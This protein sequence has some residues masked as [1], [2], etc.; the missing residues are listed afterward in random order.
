M[1][2]GRP[3]RRTG[4]GSPSRAVSRG[5][6]RQFNIY[7]VNVDGSGQHQLTRDPGPDH[8][9]AW[10]PDG[11]KIAFRSYRDERPLGGRRWQKLITS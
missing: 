9:P 3:G 2:G 1:P 10:S 5:D 6:N 4:G 7:V 11:R 8:D